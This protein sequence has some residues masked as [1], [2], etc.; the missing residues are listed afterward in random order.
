MYR[1]PL[2]P[3]ISSEALRAAIRAVVVLRELQASAGSLGA[4][5]L[6]RLLRLSLIHI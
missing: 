5:S 6:A 2:I 1:S 4:G 3:M